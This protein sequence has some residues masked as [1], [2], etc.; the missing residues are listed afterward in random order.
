MCARLTLWL[1]KRW[2]PRI[3]LRSARPSSSIGIYRFL[4]QRRVEIRSRLHNN[5]LLIEPQHPRVALRI[6]HPVLAGGV[7][8]E[9]Q[10]CPGL[11]ATAYD[12]FDA[13]LEGR[14]EDGV[15]GA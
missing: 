5:P 11:I 7:R 6:L 2:P 12:I 10:Y 1:R 14:G 4:H 3:H 15:D 8:F 9:L 13:Q